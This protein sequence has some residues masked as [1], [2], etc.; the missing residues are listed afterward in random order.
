MSTQPQ[1]KPRLFLF[2]HPRT[3]S[4]LLM[5]ILETHPDLSQLGYSFFNAYYIGP[6]RQAAS[7]RE[8][9]TQVP[10]YDKWPEMTYQKGLDSMLLWL[11]NTEETGKT[12]LI[13]NHSN[14]ITQ[15]T[16]PRET[17]PP[18]PNVKDTKLDLANPD[19]E[20]TPPLPENPTF[21]PTRFLLTLTPIFIIRHPAS[22]APSFLRA[23]TV[24]TSITVDSEEFA[25]CCSYKNQINIFEFYKSQGTEPIVVD[26]ERLV[27]DTQGVMKKLCERVG[28]DE[29]GLKYEWD[30][31]QAPGAVVSKAQDAFAGTVMRSTGVIKH[32]ASQKPIDIDEKVKKWEQEWDAEIAKAMERHVRGAMGDYEYLLKYAL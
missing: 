32:R 14:E 17:M 18:K 16:V 28:L 10:G 25:T 4:N 9:F 31:K 11:K 20:D 15:P 22:V 24:G 30:A 27:N 6:E 3:M 19:V 26:G 23:V 1:S 13:K 21:L 2:S 5:R 29:G 8:D 12:P 7:P